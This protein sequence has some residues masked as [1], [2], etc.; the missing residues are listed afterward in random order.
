MMATHVIQPQS[1]PQP[2]A[3]FGAVQLRPA[4]PNLN[5]PSTNQSYG[6]SVV[7]ERTEDH[8][9]K[10]H[11]TVQE[12]GSPLENIVRKDSKVLGTDADVKSETVQNNDEKNTGEMV[13]ESEQN[14]TVDKNADLKV[15]AAEDGGG[16]SLNS[17]D[18]KLV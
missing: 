14:R 18:G 10:N 17:S 1:F 12:V 9:V 8:V 2:S 5:Q 6:R 3:G 4:K 15:D 11:E 16:S 7:L 13:D